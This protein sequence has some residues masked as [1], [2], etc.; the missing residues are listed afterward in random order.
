MHRDIVTH[1]IVSKSTEFIIT[2]SIDGHIKFWKKMSETIEFVK[3]YQAHLGAI[4]SISLSTD[5]K[6]L[7][8]T[9]SSDK[10]IKFFD[11][12]G[13]DMS[14]M[15]A[16]PF[17][18]T[19]SVFFTG[20]KIQFFQFFIFTKKKKSGSKIFLAENSSGLLRVYQAEGSQLPI[21]EINIHSYPVK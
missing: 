8:T 21:N 20:K 1:V 9:C 3:H 2:A 4:H 7:A 15:V 14:N 12:C 17:V 18:P 10:M 16:L 19:V 5:Q 13:F 11:I 6:M